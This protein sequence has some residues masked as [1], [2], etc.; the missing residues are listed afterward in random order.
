MRRRDVFRIL[1]GAAVVWSSEVRAQ[2]SPGKVWRVAF[3]YPGSLVSAADREHWEVFRTELRKFG[4]IEGK[5]LVLD[6]RDAEGYNDRIPALVDELI[7]ARPDVFVAVAPSAAVAAHRVTSV[8]PIVMW[9]IGE[10]MAL[11]LVESLGRPGGNVTG[12]SSMSDE[13]AGKSV[14]ILHSAF[15]AARRIAVLMSTNPSHPR[16]LGLVKAA[17][18][19]LGLTVIPISAPTPNDLEQAFTDML[20]KNCEALLVL[21]DVTRPTIPSLAAK[22]KL[23]ALY[24]QTTFADSGAL[25]CYGASQKQIAR[26]TAYYVDKI[27][28]GAHP[29]DLPVEQPVTFELTVNL[30]TAAALGVRIPESVLAGADKVIE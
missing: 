18:E 19:A 2:Q 30:Q 14:E 4:Y 22:S 26:R 12:T 15:P 5:N 6:R 29:A 3:L 8:I 27:L 7:A 20:E 9:G 10:P 11:G 17:A 13:S 28:K 24:Q 25:L 21:I 1:G 23:P 16:L